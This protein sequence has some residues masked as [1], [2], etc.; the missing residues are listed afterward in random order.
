LRLSGFAVDGWGSPG[1]GAACGDPLLGA[2]LAAA[3]L[4]G[5]VAAMAQATVSA[6]AD[7]RTP[8]PARVTPIRRP[9]IR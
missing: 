1:R 2:A 7:R 5:V 4:L 3:V 6:A 9:R 8:L